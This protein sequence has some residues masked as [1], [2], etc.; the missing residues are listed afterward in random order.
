MLIE[1]LYFS[2]NEKEFNAICDLI[3]PSLIKKKEDLRKISDHDLF[4]RENPHSPHYFPFKMDLTS[5][6]FIC[7][8]EFDELSLQVQECP[9]FKGHKDFLLCL[10]DNFRDYALTRVYQLFQEYYTI[11]SLDEKKYAKYF[12]NDLLATHDYFKSIMEKINNML[13]EEYTA[14][15]KFYTLYPTNNWIKK[16]R[17]FCIHIKTFIDFPEKMFIY[18]NNNYLNFKEQILPIPKYKTRKSMIVKCSKCD[19]PYHQEKN[20]HSNV[21]SYEAEFYF[22]KSLY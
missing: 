20:K 17:M 19:E 4:A 7:R 21:G 6:H 8:Q 9:T 5:H 12:L 3:T 13:G 2:N 16:S 10:K 14:R 15:Y 22:S 18:R 1:K 11:V